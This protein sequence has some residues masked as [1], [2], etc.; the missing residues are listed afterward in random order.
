MSHSIDYKLAMNPRAVHNHQQGHQ[1][2]L[3]TGETPWSAVPS[4]GLPRTRDIQIYWRECHK[5]NKRSGAPE[6]G[7]EPESWDCSAWR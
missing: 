2:S 6:L 7:G 1:A 4:S 3:S 5:D